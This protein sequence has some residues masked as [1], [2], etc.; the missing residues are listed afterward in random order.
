MIPII[1]CKYFLVQDFKQ[2]RL[3]L[4]A[5]GMDGGPLLAVRSA[6]SLCFYDWE[7]AA[8]VRRIEIGAKKVYWNDGGEYVVIAGEES[9]YVLRYNAAAVESA[10]EDQITEDGIEDA[11]E[12]IGTF[13]LPFTL[14]FSK[15]ENNISPF[16]VR[17]PRASRLVSGSETASSS[18]TPSTES[19]TTS[20]ERL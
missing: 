17:S 3:D 8:L 2:I 7:T 18:L 11:F 5:D 4:V 19:T 20:E 6:T 1:S 12:V 13:L 16:Q 14:D 9:M 15:V 10:T